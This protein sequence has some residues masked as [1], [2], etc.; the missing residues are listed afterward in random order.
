MTIRWG[1]RLR[2]MA[3]VIACLAAPAV[4]AQQQPEIHPPTPLAALEPLRLALDQLDAS[5]GRETANDK[6]LANMRSSLDP[7]RDDIGT[8]TEALEKRL[9]DLDIRLKQIGS[10]PAAGAPPEDPTIA[11]ERT[12]L[13][14]RR[15]EVDPALKQARLL[16]LR[17]NDL[18]DRIVE[19]RRALFT[20]E[21]LARTVSVFDPG[22]WRQAAAT[23]PDNIRGVSFLARS[24]WGYAWDNG[25]FS[26][27][28]GAVLA[29]VA[30][31]AAAFWLTQW[32]RRRAI[33]RTSGATRFAK[34]SSSLIVL[35]RLALTM[36]AV[37]AALVFVVEA[38][39]L[40]PPRLVE[41]L[42]GF[43]VA[44]AV[45]SFGRAVAI[46]LC[47]PE[48]PERRLLPANELTAQRLS[49][50]FTAAARVIGFIIFVNIVQKAIVS[51]VA[52]T[53]AL[54][55]LMAAAIAGLLIHLLVRLD[56]S[57]DKDDAGA[58]AE[59]RGQWLR[60]GGWLLAVAILAALA[61][62]YVGFGAFLAGRFMS[63][64]CV[65]AA[66]Y[67]LLEFIDSL[68]TEVLTAQSHRG[69]AVALTFGLNPH[70][71]DLI[72]TSMSALI[73]LL[74]VL[75]AFFPLLGPGG[76]FAADFFGVAKESGFGIRIGDVSISLVAV[77]GGLVVL[78]LGILLTRA[79]QRWLQK[80][81]LPRTTLEPS[82][83]H[84]VSTI[85]GYVGMV[86]T[87]FFALSSVGIDLQKITLVAGALSIG[88]GFGLQS[89]VSNFVSGLIVLAERPIR[90]GDLIEVKG[91]R[92]HV[93]RIRVRATEIE[94]G[95][96]ASLIVPN[97]ELI[98]GVVKN[99]T[100]SNTLGRIVITVRVG[101]D[102]DPEKVRNILLN[103]AREHH[104][105]VRSPGPVALLNNFGEYA[106][107]FELGCMVANV[108]EGGMVRSDLRFAILKALRAEGIAIPYPQREVRQVGGA[109]SPAIVS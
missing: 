89:V 10:P 41:T 18:A 39:G 103:A 25:G 44:V 93:K 72:G 92:G 20:R 90:V 73:R 21:L 4:F 32:W 83:Q 88:I 29:L 71:I 46:A 86:A 9:N 66:L 84:S 85:F 55:A 58:T 82:L 101:Y 45:A 70:N 7:V 43:F 100:H 1:A 34:A 62:G 79:A 28:A 30:L 87:L 67:I 105:I 94:T 5:L 24:W 2:A 108:D 78:L 47:A 107:E 40:V 3:I 27:I 109:G 14:E 98:T 59:P 12:R 13:T 57:D 63:A 48:E 76:I 54:S 51:P 75:V 11:T 80:R 81:F 23:G 52:A 69:R 8:Q 22:F 104:G 102:S 106:L 60:G 17:G 6:D 42:L 64:I 53:V 56:R 15:A 65:I 97:S 61:T 16:A 95:D 19:R 36:P 35:L 99:W 74:L 50:H 91:E 31:S 38:F 49:W 77:L 37:V 96:Q 26:G 33:L 68:F